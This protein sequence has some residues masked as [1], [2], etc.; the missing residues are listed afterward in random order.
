MDDRR[1]RLFEYLLRLGDTPSVLAQRLGEWVGT[2]P[3]LEE[4]IA[5]SQ[6]RARPSRPG[7]AV[8]RAMPAKSKA[9]RA[10][11][12]TSSRSCATA[13][14]SAT[15]CWSSSRTATSPTRWRGSSISTR[16]HL[17]AA[18]GAGAHRAMPR[19][20]EIAAKAVKE[21]AYHVERSGDWVVRLGDGTDDV[22]RADADGD[23]R[24]LDVHRRDVRGRRGRR[25]LIDAGIAADAAPAR[26][27]GGGACR[28]DV[29]TKRR[30]RRRERLHARRAGTRRQAGRA[31]R[32]PRPP[33]AGDAVPAARVSG[34]AMVTSSSAPSRRRNATPPGE[35]RMRPSIHA[36]WRALDAVPDPEIPA[37]SVR[38]ARH[39]ARCLWDAAD[40]T[41]L[42]RAR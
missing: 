3:V 39:R 14:S 7:A 33:A 23:R 19:I 5:L 1:P 18:A 21:V 42:R 2:G 8:A 22:A 35:C 9:Q 41:T 11:A 4:D 40:P 20:A 32:A 36:L 30:S 29:S 34:G 27:A 15:C 17:L 13:A 6:C 28:R 38:R 10:R 24:A 26:A 16:W 37:V 31:H 12:R 25:S